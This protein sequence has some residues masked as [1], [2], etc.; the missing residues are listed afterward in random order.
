MSGILNDHGTRTSSTRALSVV[1]EAREQLQEQGV[2][3]IRRADG[4]PAANLKQ[5]RNI[6]RISAIAK[7]SKATPLAMRLPASAWKGAFIKGPA[8]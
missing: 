8:L 6:Y 5:A 7:A 4:T 2:Y 3:L 1:R